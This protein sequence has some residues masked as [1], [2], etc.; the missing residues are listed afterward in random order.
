MVRGQQLLVRNKHYFPQSF[1]LTRCVLVLSACTIGTEAQHLQKLLAHASRI[2][3]D[4][5]L[6]ICLTVLELEHSDILETERQML[7][8]SVL[9]Q[10]AGRL[11]PQQYCLTHAVKLKCE[12]LQAGLMTCHS[13]PAN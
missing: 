8:T 5:P 3:S 1:Q 2:D 4:F 12:V 7:V 11:L 13:S 6:Q 9:S 10:T